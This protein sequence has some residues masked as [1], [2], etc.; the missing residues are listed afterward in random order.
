MDQPKQKQG[1]PSA[2]AV[3]HEARSVENSAAYLI[4]KLEAAKEKKPNLTMLD[5]GAGSGSISVGFAKAI[6]EGRVIAVDLNEGILP[7]ARLLAEE[8]G[9]TNIELRQADV[10]KLPF[11]DASF[12]I[13]HCH[14]VLTHVRTAPDAL[15]E[16]LRVTKPGGFVAAREGDLDTECIWPT[17]P[18]LLKFHDLTVTFM[19]AAG[20]VSSA[21]RQLLSWALDAGAERE[22][23]TAS[24]STW[25]YSTPQEKETWA[26][27]MTEYLRGGRMRAAILAKGLAEE[28]EIDEMA[29]AWEDWATQDDAILA[30]M[31]GEIIIQK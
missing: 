15:R 11:E 31:Q 2:Q 18:A 17:M 7:R 29:E 9:V 24:F 1:Q 16:M 12:D 10:F 25:T 6:P 27:A 19:Q 21:G 22:R 23:V 28:A 13:T 30:M 8:A 4:P 20:G 3:H 5:V 14:Q 26:R